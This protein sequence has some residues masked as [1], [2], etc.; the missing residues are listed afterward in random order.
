MT[1][2]SSNHQKKYAS[3]ANSDWIGVPGV[4]NSVTGS[5]WKLN[6]IIKT[7]APTDSNVFFPMLSKRFS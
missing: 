5:T 4:K 3:G 2:G 6:I 7:V 1:S